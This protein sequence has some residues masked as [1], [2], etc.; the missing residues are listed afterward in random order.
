MGKPAKD[1]DMSTDA[2][3]DIPH[4]VRVYPYG[5]IVCSGYSIQVLMQT[6]YRHYHSFGSVREFI[7]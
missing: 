7:T 6:A 5:Q 2:K 4:A 1:P 3:L